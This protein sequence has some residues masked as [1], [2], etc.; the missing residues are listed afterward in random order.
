MCLQLLLSLVTLSQAWAAP[1]PVNDQ[2]PVSDARFFGFTCR[3]E[4]YILTVLV[5]LELSTIMGAGGL[6]QGS[7][8][9]SSDPLSMVDNNLDLVAMVDNNLDLVAMVDNNLSMRV[10]LDTAIQV[11]D[12]DP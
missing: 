11:T 3:G 10:I 6:C 12:L 5:L 4:M 1:T 8:L 2:V 9:A 7:L